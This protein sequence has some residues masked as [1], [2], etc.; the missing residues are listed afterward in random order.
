[1]SDDRARSGNGMPGTMQREYVQEAMSLEQELQRLG[2]QLHE[3]R[4]H[5]NPGLLTEHCE[6][7]RT[8]EPGHGRA[9]VLQRF[10]ET[11]QRLNAVKESWRQGSE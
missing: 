2:R 9:I 6:Q 1:M 8:K 3:R 7:C 10:N 5:L 11:R 4:C